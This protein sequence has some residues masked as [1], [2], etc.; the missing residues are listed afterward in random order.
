MLFLLLYTAYLILS[1]AQTKKSIGLS[2]AAECH[3]SSCSLA[4]VVLRGR[5]SR[6]RRHSQGLSHVAPKKNPLSQLFMALAGAHNRTHKTSV[7]A[8]SSLPAPLPRRS[9]A[10]AVLLYTNI[11]WT[12]FISWTTPSAREVTVTNS[13]GSGCSS[14]GWRGS[15]GVNNGEELPMAPKR[16]RGARRVLRHAFVLELQETSPEE[17]VRGACAKTQ[18]LLMW[19]ARAHP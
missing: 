2:F 6:G 13:G 19:S 15:R 9:W 8:R 16:R 1:K 3:L 4:A 11:S 18:F 10:Q 17:S 14:A 7:W 12:L 5:G